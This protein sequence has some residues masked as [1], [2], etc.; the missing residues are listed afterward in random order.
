MC[1]TWAGDSVALEFR[2]AVCTMEARQVGALWA[3]VY[4]SCV[5]TCRQ[6]CVA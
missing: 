2:C 1:G 5:N 3:G 6:S 4:T